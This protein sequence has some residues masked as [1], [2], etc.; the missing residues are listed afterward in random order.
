MK[1]FTDLTE[2]ERLKFAAALS[3][4]KEEALRYALDKRRYEHSKLAYAA[5]AFSDTLDEIG[6][7]DYYRPAP[8]DVEPSA[9]EAK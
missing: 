7:R 5:R 9:E 6:L 2:T 8:L 4:L 1:H 3:R